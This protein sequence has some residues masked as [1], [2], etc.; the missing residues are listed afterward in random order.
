MD[1]ALARQG[2]EHLR[3]LREQSGALLEAQRAADGAREEAEALR[4]E[5]AG[6]RAR[7]DALRARI[8]AAEGRR[9]LKDVVAAAEAARGGEAA[10]AAEAGHGLLSRAAE[11]AERRAVAERYAAHRLAGLTAFEPPSGPHA[12]EGAVGVRFDTCFRGEYGESF[13]AVLAPGLAAVV[14]H[15]LPPFVPV[16]AAA[17][18]HLASSSPADFCE[19]VR[20]YLDAYVSRRGQYGAA[21]LALGVPPGGAAHT[22]PYD[23]FEV[24]A[25]GGARVRVVYDDPTGD[26]PTRAEVLRAGGRRDAAAEAALLASTAPLDE[27]LPAAI[28]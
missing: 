18:R 5:E 1:E 27:A 7:R 3:A 25:A 28:G 20:A 4:A 14:R 8:K 15:T 11:R 6:L 2:V 24:R 13:Y 10:D 23:S 19:A 17:A 21:L 22:A 16:E 9:T 12:P 26:R